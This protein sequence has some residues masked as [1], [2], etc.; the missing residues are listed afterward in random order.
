MATR[1][2]SS[3]IQLE[4]RVDRDSFT[5]TINE[6]PLTKTTA[7]KTITNAVKASFLASLLHKPDQG[8]TFKLI[9]GS[10]CSNHFLHD[11]NYTRFADWRFIHRARLSVVPLRGLRRF[12]NASQTCSRCQRHR[13]TL[14]H[15]IN[16]CLPNYAMITKQHN[17]ILNKLYN[18]FD[19]KG[20]TVY[21]NQRIPGYPHNCQLDLVV[22]N[23]HPKTTTIIDVTTPFENGE[24]AFNQAR[25]EK[26]MKYADLAEHFKRQGYD[27]FTDAFIVGALG[28]YDQANDSTVQRLGV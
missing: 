4:W 11:G 9:S 5:P 20:L 10:P 22:A 19:R 2:L 17:A 13:E 14:A 18:A 6:R 25:T 7:M 23:E 8:K 1:R 24:E 12:G 21:V 28:G 3:R 27:T 16:H 26:I 15:V